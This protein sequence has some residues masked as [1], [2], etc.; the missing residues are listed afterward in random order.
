MKP[1]PETPSQPL[2]APRFEP[3]RVC[4]TR[5]LLDVVSQDYCI[6]CLERHLRGDWGIVCAEDAAANEQ[7]LIEGSRIF[8]VYPVNPDNAHGEDIRGN[9]L[10]I[11]TEADRSYTTLML[12][13]EY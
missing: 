8:S 13:D 1:S 10:F 9:R 5:G 12:P 7:A 4:A 11:I 3:G 6:E 2:S